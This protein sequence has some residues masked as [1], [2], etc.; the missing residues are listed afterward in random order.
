[1]RPYTN[2]IK[3]FNSTFTP[4]SLFDVMNENDLLHRI[5][6]ELKSIP[7][8]NFRLSFAQ[9]KNKISN[10]PQH[11]PVLIQFQNHKNELFR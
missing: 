2:C 9:N 5:F 8:N 1:M 3:K 4:F 11:V 10:P 6:P 7:G